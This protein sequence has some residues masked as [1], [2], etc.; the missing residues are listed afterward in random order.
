M[1]PFKKLTDILKE[2]KK[3]KKSKNDD[4]KKLLDGKGYIL[5][6]KKGDDVFGAPEESRILFSKLKNP[7]DDDI[8]WGENDSMFPAMNLLKALQ[9]DSQED[10]FSQDDVPDIQV[11]DRDEAEDHLCN[12]PDNCPCKNGNLEIPQRKPS[13]F[14]INMLKL[15]DRL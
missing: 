12:C 8:D 3:T 9:G 11:I 14:G 5:F 7:D 10:M 1:K 15:K 13:R 2:E 6:F 4:V